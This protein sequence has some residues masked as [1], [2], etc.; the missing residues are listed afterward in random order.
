MIGLI[1]KNGYLV[2]WRVDG[3]QA[4]ACPF[5]TVGPGSTTA[6]CGDWC[7]HFGEPEDPRMFEGKKVASITLTCGSGRK[8]YF[9]DGFDDRRDRWPL[10]PEEKADG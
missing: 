9:N 6:K 1:D 5:A 2:L 8:F 7:P 4:C 3:L 10:K